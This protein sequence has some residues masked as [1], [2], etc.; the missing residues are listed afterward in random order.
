MTSTAAPVT[1]PEALLAAENERLRRENRRLQEHINS[2]T[3]ERNQLLIQNKQLAA[4]KRKQEQF[5]VTLTETTACLR[6]DKDRL[7]AEVDAGRQSQTYL[8]GVL[9]AEVENKEAYRKRLRELTDPPP[10]VTPSGNPPRRTRIVHDPP[11]QRPPKW[12][13]VPTPPPPPAR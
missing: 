10:L 6:A 3:G 5:V 11:Q 12:C 7:K 1:P 2:L 9:A 13:R 8:E 4:E